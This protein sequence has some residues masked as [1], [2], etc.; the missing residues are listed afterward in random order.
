MR[1]L[2]WEDGHW[3]QLFSMLGFRPGMLTKETVTL[4][5][6]LDKADAIAAN[7]EAIRALDAAVREWCS[8]TRTTFKVRLRSLRLQP[9]PTYCC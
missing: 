2:G 7:A 3:A 9:V 5:H 1:G 8:S 6:F 4:A